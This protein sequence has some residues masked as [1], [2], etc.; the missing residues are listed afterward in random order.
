MTQPVKLVIC[1]VAV[2]AVMLGL[3]ELRPKSELLPLD[4]ATAASVFVSS[5]NQMTPAQVR[6]LFGEPDEV[7][8]A[9]PKALCWRYLEDDSGV[10]MC[11]G[12]KRD[13]AW[14]SASGDAARTMNRR[15]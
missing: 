9:N 6:V 2:L 8:R 1:S 15:S 7:F 5:G 4:L 11:W 14:I 13:Q 10:A 3:N 12:P